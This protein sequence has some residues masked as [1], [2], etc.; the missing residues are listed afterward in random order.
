M[1]WSVGIRH[2]DITERNLIWDPVTNNARLYDYDLLEFWESP[3][4]G[5]AETR[6]ASNDPMGLPCTG[7]WIFMAEELLTGEAMDDTV[8]RVY[9]HE[10]E[11]F[12]AVLVWIACRY[13][14]GKLR[15]D[16]PF[17]EWNRMDYLGVKEERTKTFDL[18][19]S[20][21]FPK[22]SGLPNDLWGVISLTLA[23]MV[24]HRN[25][26]GKTQRGLSNFT[27]RRKMF[28][29]TPAP[30][31]S[32]EDFNDLC[33]LRKKILNW[34]LFKLPSATRFVSMLRE[35]GLNAADAQQDTRGYS[36]LETES[37]CK[38][39]LQDEGD[40]R[41]MERANPVPYLIVTPK[42]E[43]VSTLTRDWDAFMTA[44]ISLFYCESQCLRPLREH[45]L[46]P[47]YRS[48]RALEHR[49]PSWRY[50]RR[51]HDVGPCDEETQALRLR[52]CTHLRTN[53]ARPGG[54]VARRRQGVF[55]HRRLDVHGKR[56]AY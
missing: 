52:P 56:L 33:A 27:L 7:T 28:P 20:G 14:D 5:F 36:E 55:Q 49:D 41:N 42:Y 53:P 15:P 26:A 23:D 39:V 6:K 22:P 10:V 4:A 1:L 34:T 12:V 11:A 45:S 24:D 50:Q 30:T 17:E 19:V 9:R 29:D 40:H 46:K 54:E 31:E 25:D 32:L 51:Q 18:I 16:L 44:F 38:A 3:Q 43:P 13:M 21:M 2:R 8:K 37:L 47:F 48:R 35:R